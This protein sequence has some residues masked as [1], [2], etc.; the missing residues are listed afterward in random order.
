MNDTMKDDMNSISKSISFTDFCLSQYVSWNII[1]EKKYWHLLAK[2]ETKPDQ[3]TWQDLFDAKTT[4]CM[5]NSH[6]PIQNNLICIQMHMVHWR[7]KTYKIRI[8]SINISLATK[9]LKLQKNLPFI[10][11]FLHS[12]NHMFCIFS[13]SYQGLLT[14]WTNPNFLN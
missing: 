9:T 2:H 7:I 5:E 1:E 10:C 4:R 8:R 6:V 3:N 13:K 12:N 11:L 14:Q